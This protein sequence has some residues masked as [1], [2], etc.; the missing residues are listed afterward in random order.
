MRGGFQGAPFGANLRRVLVLGRCKVCG[1]PVFGKVH[2]ELLSV[3]RI[4]RCGLCR[5]ALV[6]HAGP[7]DPHQAYTGRK[8][9]LF[10]ESH[11][12]QEPAKVVSRVVEGS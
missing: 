6:S 2:A 4:I 12:E 5:A 1:T 7:W 9:I 11:I 3:K 8:G 10:C